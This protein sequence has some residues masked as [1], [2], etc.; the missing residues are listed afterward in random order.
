MRS[1]KHYI[2]GLGSN[3][4]PLINYSRAI[5][6]LNLIFPKTRFSKVKKTK[7]I[8]NK[9]DGD[10]FNGAA[11]IACDLSQDELKACLKAIEFMLHRVRNQDPNAARTIDL[12]ILIADN[13]VFDEDVYK[14]D[15]LQQAIKELLPHFKI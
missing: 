3:I 11:Q 8:G 1:Q 9:H 4:D 10:F 2:I 13:C 12:D 6:L 5:N 7:P 14:R 15:F